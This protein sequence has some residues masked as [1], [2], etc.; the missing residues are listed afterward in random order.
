MTMV[1]S[2]FNNPAKNHYRHT[3]GRQHG[4]FVSTKQRVSSIAFVNLHCIEDYSDPVQGPVDVI[5]P[6][7]YSITSSSSPPNYPL[8]CPPEHQ[9]M[10]VHVFQP[11]V[12]SLCE[13]LCWFFIYS[14]SCLIAISYNM[15]IRRISS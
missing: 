11:T 15:K 3:H 14:H 1:D 5:D 7:N 6:L 8:H 9:P 12:L 13:V 2:F 10:R 4:T